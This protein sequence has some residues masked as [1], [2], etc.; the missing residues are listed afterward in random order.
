MLLESVNATIMCVEELLN[1]INDDTREPDSSLRIEDQFTGLCM[2][3]IVDKPYC[4]HV[5]VAV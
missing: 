5:Y 2:Y 4:F 3:Y 1:K